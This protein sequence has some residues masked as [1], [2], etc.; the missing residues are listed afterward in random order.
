[1]AAI[2]NLAAK[3][4]GNTKLSSSS[5]RFEHV[6]YLTAAVAADTD[7]LIIALSHSSCDVLTLTEQ[8]TII[9]FRASAATEVIHQRPTAAV[10]LQASVSAPSR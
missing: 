3:V 4:S 1:M 9:V 10:Q 2:L 5:G 6:D 8:G 7:R